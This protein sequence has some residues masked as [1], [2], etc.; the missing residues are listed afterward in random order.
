MLRRILP[1]IG[2]LFAVYNGH[3]QPVLNPAISDACYGSN[4]G[5]LTMT[6]SY[7]PVRWEM[8]TTGDVPWTSIVNQTP[9]LN[10]VNL[11]TTTWFRIVVQSGGGAELYSAPAVV[12]VSPEAKAGSIASATNVVCK[13]LNSGTLTLSGQT[14]SIV[15]WQYSND[16]SFWNDVSGSAGQ[17][18]NAY[19]NI[20]RKTWYKVLVQSGGGCT[21]VE[22]EPFVID[23]SDP[24]I[25]GSLSGTN[26]VCKG[27]NS[28]AI[29][30]SGNTGNVIRWESSL[31]GSAPWSTIVETNHTLTYANLLNTTFYRAVVK[32]GVCA[33]AVTSAA[34]V[35]VDEPSVGG[36]ASGAAGICSGINSGEVILSGYNGSVVQWQYSEDNGSLWV[37]T[38]VTQSVIDYNNLTQTRLYRA[39]IKNGICSSVKSL[40]TKITVYPLPEVSFAVPSQP[41]G[42]PVTFT[43]TSTISSG[44]LK[45]FLWD[46]H[47]GTG[48]SAKNPVHTFENGGTYKIKLEVASDKGCVDSLIKNLDIHEVPKADFSFSSVCLKNEAHFMNTSV[49]SYPAPA[50]SW[51]FGDGSP[52]SSETSPVHKYTAPGTYQVT[53]TVNTPYSTASKTMAIEVYDQATPAFETT[54]VCHG[55]NMLYLN[56]SKINSGYLTY[57]WDFGDSQ[58]SSDLNPVHGYA[59]PGSYT[60]RLITY[61]NHGCS[62]TIYKDVTV[63]PVPVAKFS[64]TDVPFG[65]PVQYTDNSTISS[66]T[67]IP[68]WN[69]GDGNTSLLKNPLHTYSSAGNYL[70]TLTVTSDSGCIA[71]LSK[72]VWVYPKPHAAFTAQA[73]CVYDS[74]PF[75]NQSTISSGNMAYLWDFGDGSASTLKDPFRKYTDPGTYQVTLIVTSDKNG[76]D[77]ITRPI[78]IYPKPTAGFTTQDVCDGHTMEFLDNSS[79]ISGTITNYLWDFGDGSNAV[80]QSPSKQYLN[81]GVYRVTLSVTSDKNC[82]SSV[83]KSTTVHENPVANFNIAGVCFKQQVLPV[84]LSLAG[85]SSTYEWDMGD[86]ALYSVFTP[87]HTYLHS[88]PFT[89]SLKIT[90]IHGCADSLKRN[91]NIYA[92]PTVDAGKDTSIVL[93]FPVQLYASGG[94]AYEWFPADGLSSA[95]I[96]NP[97]ASP[98]NTTT[99]Q[100]TVQ[101]QYGCINRDSVAITVEN[102]YTL[103]ASNILTPDGNGKNDTWYIQNIENYPDAELTIFNRWGSIVYR[104]KGYQNNWNGTNSKKDILPD[105]AYYYVITIPGSET[106][107]KGT[108]TILRNK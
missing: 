4:S 62:D 86:G 80:R 54:N 89:V 29:T 60:V 1:A 37:D 58:V 84:N 5:T 94:A 53:L 61:S 28:G 50:Y 72:T 59:S 57:A 56:K 82:K 26:I 40:Q 48:S 7:T 68:S 100:V 21:T 24:T 103:I 88:G 43:N 55:S 105:G 65:N 52:L 51:N 107:Y 85:N 64:F 95:F 75:E 17:S 13:G 104:T 27:P 83:N 81:P 38:A 19:S 30:L 41:Q 3:A 99:Y 33:E 25:A 2:L 63:N 108:V 10:Y 74:V 31:T 73:V 47:D 32:N 34:S 49:I 14:G 42:T 87:S 11:K 15:K 36:V 77:T 22:T 46:F 76:S 16:S 45:Q 90:D 8:S 12:N 78:E 97:V 9:T 20:G 101:D 92:L 23:A 69:F 93:G 66:G 98:K 67:F 39:E 70:V 79:V 35:S 102:R 96:P 44:T 106:I 6:G 91:V 18:A 71:T